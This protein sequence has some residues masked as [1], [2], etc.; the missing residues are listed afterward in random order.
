MDKRQ[1]TR[2]QFLK[3]LGYGSAAVML[4]GCGKSVLNKFPNNERLPNFVLI[5]TDDQGYADVSCFGAKCF[6]TPNIDRMAREG[7]RFTDFYACE[8]VCSASRA[9][10]MTGC[11]SKRVGIS[12]ALMPWSKV[13]LNPKEMTIAE[14]LKQKGYATGM[15]G[16]W[17]LGRQKQFLPLQQGFDEYL[18]LPYSNDMWPHDYDGKLVTKGWKSKYPPL[19]L[20]DGNEVVATIDSFKDQDTLTTRYTKRAVKFINNHKD[21]PFFLYVAH[22]MAHVPLG[23]SSKFRGKSKQ[24]LYGDVAME[25]DWSVGQILK[26]LK[27]NGLDD[28][29]LVVFTSDNG[30]W[31]VFGNNAGSAD[32]LREG[33]GTSWDGGQREPCVMRWP[34]HIPAGRVCHKLATTMDIL[35]TF[36]YLAGAPL[37]KHKIDGVNIWPLM[38]GDRFANPR[39]HFFFYYGRYEGRGKY[40]DQLQ[41]VRQGKW[42]LHLPHGYRSIENPGAH[43]G[44]CR[45]PGNYV[46]GHTGL[47]LYNLETDIGERH[48]VADKHPKVVKRLMKLVEQARK[49]LGDWNIKGK[50]VR[51]VGRVL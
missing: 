1:T 36:A 49:D 43:R 26:A 10:L 29:T 39:D 13:G 47:A 17:H 4:S 28:N 22:S 20:I 35:P 38:R 19:P 14:V 40:G 37:P 25:I 2:R 44:R 41:C 15:V 31:L 7:M 12:G 21:E 48:N 8:A 3:T 30:P 32:P 24:G 11:Y 45:W 16:K 51:P 33:K 42:K 46:K 5:F 6:K 34:G 50:G 9:A 27:D 23:V 18:G